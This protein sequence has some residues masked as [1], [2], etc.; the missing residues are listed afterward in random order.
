MYSGLLVL[1]CWFIII[2]GK[3]FNGGTITWA[4]MDPYTNASLIGITLTQS[5]SWTYPYIKCST[6]VPVSSGFGSTTLRCVVD[7]NTDGGYATKPISTVTDCI[8]YSASLSMLSAERT[9]NLTL[10]KDAHFY[11][12][13]LGTAWVSLN[14]PRVS[15][16]E[17]SIVTFIDLRKRPDGFINTPPVVKIVSPQY[18]FVNTTMAIKIPVSDANAGDDVRCRWSVYTSGY[19]RRRRT[20]DDEISRR[21]QSVL[22]FSQKYNQGRYRRDPAAD[23]CKDCTSTCKKDCKCDCDTCDT[24]VCVKD[25]CDVDV[26]CSITTTIISTAATT[27]T[28]TATAIV[29]TTSEIIG[30]LKS[31][32]SYPVRQAIDECGGICYPG[33]VPSTTS[34]SNC[35][36][37][38]TGTKAGVWYGIALQV[39]FVIYIYIS[40]SYYIFAYI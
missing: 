2:Q 1:L 34:L 5:Y 25:K 10:A 39:D 4:P 28:T 8:S 38:F 32:S 13:N 30:T 16:L 33:S 40:I 11:L 24:S 15:D 17:W 35:T 22:Q 19:R 23:E 37:T 27:A 3:H 20:A 18:V 31:T 29:S 12:A 7:C 26:G 21:Q 14:Y 36:L 9:N 6:N